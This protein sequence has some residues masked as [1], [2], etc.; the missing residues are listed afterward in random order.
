M[1][2]LVGL[3]VEECVVDRQIFLLPPGGERI[4]QIIKIMISHKNA[5]FVETYARIDS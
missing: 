3:V 5:E 1:R 2:V 4:N